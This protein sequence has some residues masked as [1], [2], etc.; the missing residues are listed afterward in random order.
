MKIITDRDKMISFQHYGWHKGFYV[1]EDFG[2]TLSKIYYE[3]F[4][5]YPDDE[6]F[7]YT[8]AWQ[9]LRG[10]CNHFALG[11]KNVLGYTP[12]IIEGDNKVSF[13]SFCQIYIKGTWYNVDARGVTTSFDEFMEVAKEFVSDK[14]TIRAVNDKDIEEWKNDNFYDEAIAFAE[15]VIKQYKEC[16]TI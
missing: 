2:D 4:F 16:Y 15:A 7:P 6:E 8:A 13:H 5:E 3:D 10:S 12:Y 1:D 9:L 14:Y 11:L